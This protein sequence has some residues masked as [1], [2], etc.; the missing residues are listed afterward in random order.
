MTSSQ[1]VSVAIKG[2]EIQITP[3]LAVTGTPISAPAVAA[4]ENPVAQGNL[5]QQLFSEPL[6]VTDDFYLILMVI[7]AIALVLNIFIKIR[8]QY[9]R[10]IF[11]GLLVIVVAGLF[12]VLNQNVAL[13][14]AAIL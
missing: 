10:L 3:T 2:T 14:H 11:G 9:P 12:I 1:A 7:F 4:P 5:V 8:V 6:T 13:L